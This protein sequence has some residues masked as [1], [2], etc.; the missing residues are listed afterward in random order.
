MAVR[1]PREIERF[2]LLEEAGALPGRHAADLGH[3]HAGCVRSRAKYGKFVGRHCQ[4]DLV[5]ITAAASSM[6]CNLYLVSRMMFSLAR[7]GYAPSSW[8]RVSSRGTPVR[9]L[10]VSAAGLCL[11]MLTSFLYPQ[12]AFVYLFGISLFGGLYAW[13]VIFVTH[14]FFRRRRAG[15][16]SPARMLGSALGSASIV[17][18]LLTTWWVEGMRIA[19][20]AGVSWLAVLTVAYIM[21]NRRRRVLSPAS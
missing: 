18:I 7:S 14:L 6:N 5:V 11:A 4:D 10:L 9:A 2:T 13:L 8:G 20:I 21:I 3:R 16:W 15:R 17:A 1:R 19:L 12:S